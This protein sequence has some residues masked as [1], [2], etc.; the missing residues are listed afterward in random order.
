MLLLLHA[1]RNGEVWEPRRDGVGVSLPSKRL[2][3]T[4]ESLC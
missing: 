3:G 2:V 1:M 4:I